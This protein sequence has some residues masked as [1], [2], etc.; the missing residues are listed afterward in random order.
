[1]VTEHDFTL[2]SSTTCTMHAYAFIPP[3]SMEQAIPNTALK[4][5]IKEGNLNWTEN[6]WP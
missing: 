6:L 4:T 5:E 3:D 1:M 2:S